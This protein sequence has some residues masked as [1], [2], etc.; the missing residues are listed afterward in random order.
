MEILKKE[1]SIYYDHEE[2]CRLLLVAVEVRIT[3]APAVFAAA[4]H[5]RMIG[6]MGYLLLKTEVHV[7]T[8]IAGSDRLAQRESPL[9]L[10]TEITNIFVPKL[11]KLQ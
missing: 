3:G 6:F 11:I 8:L 2:I 5:R 1:E 9:K 10:H 4:L 7:T